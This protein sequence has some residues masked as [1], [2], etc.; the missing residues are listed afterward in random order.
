M[1]LP[2]DL[3]QDFRPEVKKQ[4]RVT[5]AA[6]KPVTLAAR[7]SQRFAGGQEPAWCNSLETG[8]QVPTLLL[9]RG[10]TVR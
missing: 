2:T 9:G 1:A 6:G 4:Q 3:S 10:H 8:L 7:T 5:Q